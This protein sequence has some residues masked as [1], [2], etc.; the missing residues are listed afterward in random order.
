M[1]G[2]AATTATGTAGQYSGQRLF[3]LLGNL[4]QDLTEMV[5]GELTLLKSEITAALSSMGKDGAMIV[6]GGF[7]AY[8][9]AIFALV[10]IATLI[11]FALHAAGLSILMS[12]WISFL[13]FGLAI[14]GAGYG[15]LK[16]GLSNFKKVSFAPKETISTMKEI[17]SGDTTA[18]GIVASRDLKDEKGEKIQRA[19][20][21]AEK[22]I[23]KV[24]SELAEVQARMKPQYMWKAT[25][26]AV[27][28]RPKMTAGIGAAVIALGYVMAK[29]RHRHRNGHPDMKDY[30]LV[31]D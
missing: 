21:V 27:K 20:V 10:G 22:R 25:C 18:A 6:I 8:T 13:A 23:E 17:V 4:R 26:T 5:K 31:L 1:N 24:Q 19:R 14:A 28:R 7:I 30:E 16:S 9:G 12:I 29:R 15:V 11:A 2:N 3:T